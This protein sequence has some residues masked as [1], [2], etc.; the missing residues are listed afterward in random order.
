MPALLTT[1]GGPLANA[2]PGAD[3]KSGLPLHLFGKKSTDFR[4]FTEKLPRFDNR[5]A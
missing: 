3:G 4:D 1:G 2:R 5:D